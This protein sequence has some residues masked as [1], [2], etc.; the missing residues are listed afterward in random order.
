MAH[1]HQ[2]HRDK[3]RKRVAHVLKSAGY[4]HG[5]RAPSEK[6]GGGVDPGRQPELKAASAEHSDT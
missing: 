5:G 6:R 1:S 3:G 4:G 2:Q